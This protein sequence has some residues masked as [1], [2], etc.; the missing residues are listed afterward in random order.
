MDEWRIKRRMQE[1][2]REKDRLADERMNG[3]GWTSGRTEASIG[4]TDEPTKRT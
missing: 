3:S 1:R 2:E 4:E